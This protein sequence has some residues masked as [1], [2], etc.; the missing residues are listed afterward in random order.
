[1]RLKDEHGYTLVELL[2]AILIIGTLAAIALPGFLGQK[3]KAHDATVKA[4]LRNAVSEMESCY[5]LLGTYAGCPNADHPLAVDA[6]ATVTPDAKG[7]EVSKT[8]STDTVFT[9]KRLPSGYSHTCTRPNFGGCASD[10]S[11]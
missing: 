5:T 7:Y 10:G 4:D 9:V 6:V 11:W 3:D 1:M 8:S 2:V